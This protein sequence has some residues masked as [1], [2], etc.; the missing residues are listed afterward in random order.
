MVTDGHRRS[1]RLPEPSS[2]ARHSALPGH[3]EGVESQG[4]V[5]AKEPV[6]L[7]PLS[8]AGFKPLFLPFTMRLFL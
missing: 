4:G 3:N 7:G 2:L 8:V 6:C 1:G 5:L